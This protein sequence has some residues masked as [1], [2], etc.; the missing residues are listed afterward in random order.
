MNNTIIS[1]VNNH[2][3][4]MYRYNDSDAKSMILEVGHSKIPMPVK[5]ELIT[6]LT[7]ASDKIKKDGSYCPPSVLMRGPSYQTKKRNNSRLGRY[8]VMLNGGGAGSARTTKQ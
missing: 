2:I 3:K 6:K 5:C 4:E 8:P 7:T 1:K